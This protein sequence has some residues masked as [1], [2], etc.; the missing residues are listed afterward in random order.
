MT[1]PP[2]I[3]GFQSLQGVWKSLFGLF[4]LRAHFLPFTVHLHFLNIKKIPKIFLDFN[5]LTFLSMDLTST[6]HCSNLKIRF[7]ELS[8]NLFDT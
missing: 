2:L 5:L 4:H 3:K 6:C 7:E 1:F 8:I